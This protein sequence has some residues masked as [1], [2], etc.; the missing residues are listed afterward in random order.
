MG[1]F[2]STQ[3]EVTQHVFS[4]LKGWI[5]ILEGNFTQLVLGEPVNETNYKEKNRKFKRNTYKTFNSFP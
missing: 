5:I 2:H 1:I 3:L 4:F